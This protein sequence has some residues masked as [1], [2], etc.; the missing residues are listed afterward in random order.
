MELGVQSKFRMTERRNVIYRKY[1]Q[2]VFCIALVLT[3]LTGCG[4]NTGADKPEH[5]KKRD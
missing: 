5:R 3:V 2:S 1:L 4:K